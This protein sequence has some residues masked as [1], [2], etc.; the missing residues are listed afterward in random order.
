MPG[1]ASVHLSPGRA[2]LHPSHTSVAGGYT[3]AEGGHSRPA[4]SEPEEDS[5]HTPWEDSQTLAQVQATA[6]EVARSRQLVR[7]LWP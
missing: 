4:Q 7:A 6:V 1:G 5:Q 2:D 3:V